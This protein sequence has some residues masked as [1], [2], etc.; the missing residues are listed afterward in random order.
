VIA[1]D[2]RTIDGQWPGKER[3]EAVAQGLATSLGRGVKRWLP[4][5]GCE[6]VCEYIKLH[7]NGSLEA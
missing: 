1:E 3:A 6:G 7:R 5:E 2:D 4:P